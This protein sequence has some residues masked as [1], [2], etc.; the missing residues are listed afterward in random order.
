MMAR[1]Q[2]KMRRIR[3]L[4]LLLSLILTN[5]QPASAQDT[6]WN[7]PLGGAFHDSGNW[8]GGVPNSGSHANFGIAGT[9]TVTFSG[10]AFS[11]RVLQQYGDVTFDLG[12]NTY[13][14][15]SY[16][17][18]G[19]TYSSNCTLTI[20]NGTVSG[21]SDFDA[22]DNGDGIV[23]ILSSG[24]VSN[25]RGY[26][27]KYNNSSGAA[28]VDGI[29]NNSSDLNVGFRSTSS[30]TLTVQNGGAVS[31]VNG[32]L[33]PVFGTSG[34]ATVGGSNSTWSNSG[35]LY[36][37]GV[38]GSSGG[39]GMLSVNEGGTVE[40]GDTLKVWSTGTANLEGGTINTGSFVNAGGT[41]NLNDGT[42]TV[43]GGVFD[44]GTSTF[45][46]DGAA[47]TDLPTLRLE[48]GATSTGITSDFTVGNSRQG[49]L[50]VSGGSQL[51]NGK[52]Y[53][54]REIGSNGTATVDGAD[55][56]WN[57]SG[58]LDV[59]YKGRGELNITNGGEVTNSSS[60]SLGGLHSSANGTVTVDGSGSR[61]TNSGSL[62]V[63][64][65]GT[66]TLIVENGGDVSNTTGYV[67]VNS[68]SSTSF[69]STVTVRDSGSTWTNSESLYVGGRADQ[70][71]DNGT[72]FVTDGA[73]VTVGDTLKTWHSGAIE[74]DNARISAALIE[75]AG[76]L[77][78]NG[79]VSG[80][81]FNQA[82]GVLSGSGVFEDA[83]TIADGSF[84][85]P[86]N[87]PGT[88]SWGSGVLEGGGGLLWEINDAEG[89]AG[90]NWD[91]IEVAGTLDITADSASPFLI[92]IDT[93]D[94]AGLAANFD[95]TQDYSWAF[96]TALNI[97]GFSADAFT[98]NLDGFLNDLGGGS[99]FVSM[100]NN[101][102]AI[103]FDGIATEAVPEPATLVIWSLFCLM[104]LIAVR[105]RSRRREVA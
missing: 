81:V 25:V 86:G 59:G 100:D 5:M 20:S 80:N 68:V 55:S 85:S 10:N 32:F 67:A 75:N 60:A 18:V 87:S 17:A 77:N 33:G 12:G 96:L 45:S 51:S 99:F 49:A 6:Y 13:D 34:T 26:V 65:L 21:G 104:G 31:N 36:V 62:Q 50:V 95:N 19:N 22:G 3:N 88:M 89:T 9:Y 43:N 97:T 82:G 74:I 73:V 98:F 79:T 2:S 15:N 66:G 47:A 11:R 41:L 24:T 16:V 70:A 94:T 46:I 38:A 54:G 7:D 56:T 64:Q 71:G 78:N 72:V 48:G 103:N 53:I 61:W 90:V 28:T 101:S 37:G 93:D 8:S 27:G 35:S 102:L 105:R 92:D 57:N 14:F 52:G 29:W 83:V 76:R 44:S 23:N 69:T 91:L 63:G 1:N 40:V 58:A 39:S 4:G 42:L 84:V 30:G